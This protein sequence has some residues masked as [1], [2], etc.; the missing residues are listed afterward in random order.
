IYEIKWDGYRAIADI[1]RKKVRLYSRNGVSFNDRFYPIV[2]S[3]EK[4]AGE[5]VLDGEV[6][7]LDE[8]GKASFQQLQNSLKTGEG[9]FIYY[10]FDI[11][12]VN[13]CDLRQLPLVRRKEILKKILQNSPS[14]IQ[15][16][17]HVEREGTTFFHAA[18]ENG[19]EGIMAKDKLSPY[20]SGR[21]PQW[22]KIKILKRQE[23]VIGGFTEPRGNRKHLG[24][25]ILG[26]YEKNKLKYIGHTGGGYGEEDLRELRPQLE[27]RETTNCPFAKTPKP[28]A[29]VHWVKP[30]LVC[31]VSFSG[32]TKD[33]IMR[34]PILLGLR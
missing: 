9:N 15:Y 30:E 25:V 33:G 7:A 32:W 18:V 3:L 23:A 1:R 12:F 34:Q 16:V 26:V 17:D 2:E 28:N 8:Q 21:F 20:L 24:A 5:Y 19:L 4:I 27:E 22:K 29:K 14:N 31:E 11:L 10:V 13:Q 6:V